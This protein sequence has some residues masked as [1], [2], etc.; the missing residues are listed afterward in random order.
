MRRHS[1]D[2]TSVFNSRCATLRAAVAMTAM[3]VLLAE[4]FIWLCPL[5]MSRIG[6]AVAI[7]K[8]RLATA[9]TAHR[10]MRFSPSR[11]LYQNP[12]PLSI[13]LIIVYH[14]AL[15][16]FN[17]LCRIRRPPTG[18]KKPHPPPPYTRAPTLQHASPIPL[19]I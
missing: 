18:P 16:V 17:A 5:V 7:I 15:C 10:V 19:K 1:S 2:S 9:L 8:Y 11:A 6:S 13:D 4:L 14:C 12:R 3:R